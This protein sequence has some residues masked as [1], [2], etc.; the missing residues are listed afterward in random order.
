MKKSFPNLNKWMKTSIRF[1]QFKV[2]L[3]FIQKIRESFKSTKFIWILYLV[4]KG[5]TVFLLFLMPQKILPDTL[6]MAS[7]VPIWWEFS[8]EIPENSPV[9]LKDHKPPQWL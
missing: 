6:N 4:W 3:L 8:K 1:G 9:D 7:T 2:D 5:Q